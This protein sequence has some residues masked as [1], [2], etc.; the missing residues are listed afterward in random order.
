MNPRYPGGFR[1][2]GEIPVNLVVIS[3]FIVWDVVQETTHQ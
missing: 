3:R 1:E 2:G